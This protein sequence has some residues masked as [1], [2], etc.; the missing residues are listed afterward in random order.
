V[1]RA[2]PLERE[3]Q[4]SRRFRRPLSLV[5]ARPR[6]DGESATLANAL[7]AAAREVDQ[8][9][10]SGGA[11]IAVLAEA[12]AAAARAFADRVCRP[13]SS[14]LA[15]PPSIA[16][17]PDDG[18][19][20]SALLSVLHGLPTERIEAPSV[21]PPPYIVPTRVSVLAGTGRAK[22]G[23]GDSDVAERRDKRQPVG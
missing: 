8:V 5:R 3:L 9:W 22:P 4:R 10:E 15:E 16:T 20:L 6:A 2:D 13:I 1:T 19:T 21:E 18:L 14:Q 11:V 23:R 12:D 17:F 7:R